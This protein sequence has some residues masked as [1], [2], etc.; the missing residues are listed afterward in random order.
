MTRGDR[1]RAIG[2]ERNLRGVGRSGY[3]IVHFLRKW[4]VQI[5]G[6]RQDVGAHRVGRFAA[7][8]ADPGGPTRFEQS[9]RSGA[10]PRVRAERRARRVSFERWWKKLEARA[11]SRRK[12]G[13]D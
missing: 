6:W 5:H 8:R 12:H 11:F 9:V 3:A 13:S 7:D 10:G 1:G 2:F 4:N